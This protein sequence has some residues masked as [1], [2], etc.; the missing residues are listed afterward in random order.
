ME[1]QTKIVCTIGPATESPE[2]IRRLIKAGMNVA[3]LNFSHGTHEQKGQIID[4]IRQISAELN[5]PIAI[6]QD[7][8]GP[9][10]R[11]GRLVSDSPVML[12]ENADFSLI[13]EDIEGDQSKVATSYFN[14]IS[15]RLKM[16]DKI[17]LADG[18][19]ELEVK[20]VSRF[21]IK[22]KVVA[23]GDLR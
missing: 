22:C 13:S 19:I 12:E 23:G 20:D 18:S 16:G 15:L 17:F 10:I 2:M 6:L 8:S 9:K 1:R 14:I 7:L 3:R 5:L 4:S 21:E 11:T